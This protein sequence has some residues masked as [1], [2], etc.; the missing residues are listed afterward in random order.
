MCELRMMGMDRDADEREFET[1]YRSG[2]MRINPRI[3][4]GTAPALVFLVAHQFTS[5]PVAILISF[6]VS[7]L[8]FVRNSGNGII[9]ALSVLSF[10]IVSLAAVTGIVLNSDSAFVAQ[11]LVGDFSIALVSVGSVAI[12]RPLIGAIARDVA[13]G[14]QPVMPIGHPTFVMLTLLN[15]AMSIASGVARIAMFEILSTDLYVIFSRVALWPTQAWFLWFCYRQ[16]TRAAIRIW[17][18]DM[19]PP[20]GWTGRTQNT[21]E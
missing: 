2:R 19:P 18:V 7:A 14:I 17:P 1:T 10:I 8:V 11:N 21:D 6:A 5:T 20:V 13:P 9:R 12:R 16:V 4:L 15:A 3:F